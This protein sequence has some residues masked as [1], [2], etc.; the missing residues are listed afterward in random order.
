M[1]HEGENV[2]FAIT[3][4]NEVH[5]Q[6]CC[7]YIFE[8]F[9]DAKQFLIDQGFKEKNRVFERKDY[10]WSK[11][12]KAYISPRKVYTSNTEEVEIILS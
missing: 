7:G 10:N 2:M 9:E 1:L 12:L 5:Q 3:Y 6:W 8:K 11:Y 4:E